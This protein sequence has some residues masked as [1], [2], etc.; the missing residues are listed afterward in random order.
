MKKSVLILLAVLCLGLSFTAHAEVL[1]EGPFT[2][3]DNSDGTA[4]ITD[5]AS[6]QVSEVVQI[7]GEIGGL[8]VTAI[9]DEAF[10]RL[11][12]FNGNNSFIRRPNPCKIILPDSIRTI[13]AK[14]FSEAGL[15]EINIPD[16]VETIGPGAFAHCPFLR[17]IISAD[18]PR[19]AVI[20]NALYNKAEKELLWYSSRL[21]AEKDLVIPE[22]I[23][24]IGDYALASCY[25]DDDVS[26]TV[27]LPSTLKTIG[28]Y[29]FTESMI[30][31]D[32]D[33]LPESLETIGAYAFL[34]AELNA[35][36]KEGETLTIPAT[37]TSLGEGCFQD[38]TYR[39]HPGQGMGNYLIFIN[40]PTDSSLKVIPT[41]CFRESRYV[42]YL[43]TNSIE[44]I[45]DYGFSTDYTSYDHG[46]VFPM[47]GD[48]IDYTIFEN[49][50]HVGR[51]GITA[52]GRNSDK[53]VIAAAPDQ[54]L[55]A[56]LTV[57][58]AHFEWRTTLPETATTIEA[59]AYVKPVV[60]FYLHAG[61]T[62]IAP[63]AFAIGSTFVVE[64]SS[65]AEA[66]AKENSFSYTVAGQEPD[67][68][69]L[70]Q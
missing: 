7:P 40:I 9:G 58:P 14:A 41:N 62:S 64:A 11:E 19:F 42:I 23:V 57:I 66:W 38:T 46:V 34:E 59:R 53:C 13:G 35:K 33:F 6:S 16:G 26:C 69:W 52:S 24:S 5:Y 32:G 65:Y 2:Y 50:T 29:A 36:D 15:T 43:R 55:T 49:L 25:P 67:L 27:V 45:E 28:N 39:V 37:V 70:D 61:F 47:K 1:K 18:H 54:A 17:F 31:I 60:D 20:D 44:R 51:Y 8:T 12:S 63:D 30:T 21:E 22:G 48:Q 10:E 4:T 68:S 56:P 3:Q